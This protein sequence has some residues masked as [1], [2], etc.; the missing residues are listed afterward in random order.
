MSN[1]DLNK[2]LN[3]QSD[4]FYLI[5]N[6]SKAPMPL[7]FID[8]DVKIE[9][10]IAEIE[11]TQHYVNV[12]D[13][14]IET[15]FLFPCD[16]DS[17]LTNM[18][19]QFKLKDGTQREIVTIIDRKEKIEIKYEESVAQGQTA[20]TGAF[21][22]LQRNLVRIN[23]GNFPPNSEAILK[24]K[25]YTTLSI[26]DLSYCFRLPMSYVP[27]YIGDVQKYINTGVHLKGIDKGS[28]L[29]EEEK[30]QNEQAVSE[31]YDHPMT[32]SSQ[33]QAQWSI[34]IELRMQGQIQRV[35]SRNHGFEYN[36]SEDKR[37]ALIKLKD[38]EKQSA[39]EC[40]LILFIRDNLTNEPVAISSM[41]EFGEQSVMIGVLPDLR[42]PKIRDRFLNKINSKL[43]QI[44]TDQQS[45]YEDENQI[46]DQ[47]EEKCSQ[48]QEEIE[49]EPKLLE[50]VFLIDR[51][52]SMQGQSIHLAVQALQ[53]FL[54]SLP[55][56]CKFNVVSFG[57]DFELLFET[58]QIYDES[59]FDK[60]VS[61]IAEF[62]ADMGGTEIAQPL[63]EIFS[64]IPDENLPRHIYL[65]T[66][67]EVSNTEEVIELVKDNRNNSTVHTFGIGDGVSTELI[68]KCAMVG[69]GHYSFIDNPH[70]IE[71]KV[72]AALQKN[73]LEYLIIQ[74]AQ[75]IDDLGE[76]I[77][78]DFEQQSNLSH[79]E[80]HQQ[81]VLLKQKKAI[82]FLVEFLDPNTNQK[83]QQ[84]IN[85]EEIQSEALNKIV[86]K[87]SIDRCSTQEEQLNEA[88][89]YQILI[90]GVGMIANEK[91]MDEVTQEM[92]L[93]KIP[94]V[95]SNGSMQIYA[96]T[97]TGKQL[98]LDCSPDETIEDIKNMINDI[99]GIPPD[100]QRLIF[101]GK[102]LDDGKTL[103]DYNIQKESTLHLVL[104]LRGGGFGIDCIDFDSKSKIM[105]SY[106]HQIIDVR[107]ELAQ[108][109]GVFEHQLVLIKD[110][111][112]LDD[113]MTSSEA[114]IAYNSNEIEYIN[115]NYKSIVFCQSANGSWTQKL[116]SMLNQEDLAQ[117]REE[118]EDEKLKGIDES[119]L[120]TLVGIKILKEYFIANK[121]E[122][123][124]VVAKGKGYLK[125][126]HG[127]SVAEINQMIELV[128]C[129]TRY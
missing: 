97:L 54:H 74:K 26:Q 58:S 62:E 77:D 76:V 30:T 86:E 109:L 103:K 118:Q 9:Q 46:E 85:I 70:E 128:K 113:G 33:N 72:I 127:L 96:K 64:Q 73:F 111:D 107:N 116:Y 25:F 12:E 27:K 29:T 65:L 31:I 15:V 89:K 47:E 18:Q 14:P 112:I 51:S 23:I 5:K 10:R 125:K 60:A 43:G 42:R 4:A 56:G 34:Q 94:I 114:G 93:R 117:L 13:N 3:E 122:W 22:K 28:N 92:K 75:L 120:L 59:T 84:I 110:G 129:S 55:M 1:Q 20:V 105:V 82:K 45:L 16:I 39:M 102:Q 36:F 98:T 106:H 90:P 53:L 119:V 67:G 48:D 57:S 71:E 50:Y 115:F 126:S 44:D 2:L 19:I 40:D 61:T 11:M 81:L 38:Y 32:D 87:A 8:F 35:S 101:A 104:R 99:E 95:K 52:G 17:V 80:I 68:K 69:G 78:C 66:D 49:I 6:D 100:Q 83:S 79:N 63:F 123:T 88:I 91:I 121:N 41:N 124:L 108:K 7:K 37:A 21:T 24:L